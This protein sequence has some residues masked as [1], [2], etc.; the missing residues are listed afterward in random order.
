[1]RDAFIFLTRLFVF[2]GIVCIVAGMLRM[3]LVLVQHWYIRYSS[4]IV[5]IV[6]SML[7]MILVQHWYIRYHSPIVCVVAGMLRTTHVHH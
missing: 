4:F 2:D 5:Y 3:I 7:R 1:M 6:A